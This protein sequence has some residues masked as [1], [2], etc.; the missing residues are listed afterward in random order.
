MTTVSKRRAIVSLGLALGMILLVWLVQGESS[1]FYEYFLYHVA[2][3]NIVMGMHVIPYLIIV[4]WRPMIYGEA[5]AYVLIF[6][7]WLLVGYLLSRLII[8]SDIK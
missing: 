7:Q 8:R 2:I 4:I 1:P 6:L 5:I 3:P